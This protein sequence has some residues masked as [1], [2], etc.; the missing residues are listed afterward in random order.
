MGYCRNNC[1]RAGILIT[2]ET[3]QDT[4]SKIQQ[5]QGEIDELMLKKLENNPN[6]CPMCDSQ[7]IHSNGCKECESCGYSPCSI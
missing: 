2:E 1:F 5:L 3:K 7:L 4:T 6:K